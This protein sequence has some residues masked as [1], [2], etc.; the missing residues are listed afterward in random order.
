MKDWGNIPEELKR[1]KQWVCYTLP[2]KLPKNPRTGGNAQSN[3]RST[4]SDYKTAVQAVEKHNFNGI[5]FMFAPPYFGVD[6]DDC[7][8]ELREEF[9]ETLHSYAEV[10]TSGKGIHIICKGELPEGGRRRG[11]VEMYNTGRYFIMTGNIATDTPYPIEDCTDQIKIL[12]SKYLSAVPVAMQHSFTRISM[13]DEELVNKARD[14][15][16]GS[17]FQLL[18]SGAWQGAYSS[19]SE[20]DLALCSIL[21]FWCQKDEAQMDRI[22]RSSGLM[23]PK[24]DRRQSGTTYGKLTVSKAAASCANVYEPTRNDSDIVVNPMKKQAYIPAKD[25]EMTDSGNGQRFADEHAGNIKYSHVHKKWYYWDGKCWREDAVGNIKVL[26][27]MTISNMKKQAFSIEDDEEQE[28]FLK[29]CRHTSNSKGKEAMIKESMH[30]S[31]VP[32]LTNEFDSAHEYFNCQNGVIN[33]RN[34]ELMPHSA[35]LMMSKIGNAELKAGAEHPL[36]DKFLLEIMDGDE[37]LIRYLQ[38]AIGYSLSG[39]TRE[40]CAFFLYG[41]GSNGK[42]TFLDVITELMGNYALNAQPETVM[43]RN[44]SATTTSDI[45]RLQSARFVTTTEPSEGMRLNEGL[46]KQLTGNDAITAR[47]LY[48]QE[49]QF[50]PEFKLWMAT[51]HKPIIRGTDN[52]IWRRIHLIPFTVSITGDKVDKALPY[53]LKK[54]LPAILDWAVQGC[55]L[56]QKEGLSPP[57]SVVEATKEYRAEMDIMNSFIECCIDEVRGSRERASEVFQ[58][59]AKWADENNEWKMSATR[60]GKEFGKRYEKIKSNGNMMYI[61]ISVRREYASYGYRYG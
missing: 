20:A 52:G 56:W 36:W 35:G 11:G 4:W 58:A 12:H 3:N 32:V 28:R 25:Y 51:N 7:T 6:L 1:V 53:K 54:E 46:I 37:D 44:S 10:S 39:S 31:G 48:G 17:L 57:A 21:A 8:D 50:K 40:Q 18:Y 33:L 14:C 42:S 27:D 47:F 24:W 26:A 13:D 60:F 9:I 38:K 22:F 29:W 61:G 16:S 23:R 55:I 41:T 45:A 59:Y 49:F 30:L 2:D 43:V 34:G 19:Q 5:G 15:R